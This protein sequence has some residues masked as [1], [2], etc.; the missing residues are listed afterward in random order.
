MRSKPRWR[1]SDVGGLRYGAFMTTV[2]WV[3]VAAGLAALVLGI[4]SA[5]HNWRQHRD[6]QLYKVSKPIRRQMRM[7]EHL[8]ARIDCL[9]DDCPPILHLDLRRARLELASYTAA[10]RDTQAAPFLWRCGGVLILLFLM[11]FTFDRID[12][13]VARNVYVS[14]VMGLYAVTV[15]SLTE[16]PARDR[17]SRL[18][19]SRLGPRDDLPA[20][21]PMSPLP[22]RTR[23]PGSRRLSNLIEKAV[24]GVDV[25][26]EEI[27]PAHVQALHTAIQRWQTERWTSRFIS[28]VRRTSILVRGWIASHV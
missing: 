24:G 4:P 23:V 2:P 16:V 13:G 28:W 25:L 10:S 17:A 14:I 20:L 15:F 1:L 8:T 7:I 12:D 19:Y 5:Q 11:A 18:L 21:P 27:T 6:A 22:F 9:G 26:P 3:S